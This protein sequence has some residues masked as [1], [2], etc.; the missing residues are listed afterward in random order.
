MKAESDMKLREEQAKAK[1]LQDKLDKEAEEKRRAVE[2]KELAEAKA[3][4]APERDKL[5]EY[6]ERL[7][8]I[9]APDG[10]SKA[11]MEIIK[12]AENK[13]LELSQ[14]IKTLT[15]QL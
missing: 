14:E 11:G 6:A 8:S 15:N 2:E 9:E 12:K 1:A 10:L 13:L 3:K 5:N 7:K 4:L